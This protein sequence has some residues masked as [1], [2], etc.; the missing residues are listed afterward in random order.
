MADDAA[1]SSKKNRP[2]GASHS[3]RDQPGEKRRQSDLVCGPAM[4]A[5]AGPSSQQTQYHVEIRRNAGDDG[6]GDGAPAFFLAAR[7]PFPYEVSRKQVRGR[8][9]G[10]AMGC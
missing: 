10:M 6:G 1:Q 3:L 5:A 2:P 9:H 4:G 7:L 8:G